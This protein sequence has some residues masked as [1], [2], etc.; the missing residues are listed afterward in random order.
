MKIIIINW[1]K[2]IQALIKKQEKKR[3]EMVKCK[4][5]NLYFDKYKIIN[6]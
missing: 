4:S 5:F 3:F 2:I 1:I 6:K